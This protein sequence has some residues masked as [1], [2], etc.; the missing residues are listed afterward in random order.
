LL[1]PIRTAWD[2]VFEGIVLPEIDVF[3]AETMAQPAGGPETG[4]QARAREHAEN[5]ADAAG[6]IRAVDEERAT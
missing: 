4:R 1:R 5:G 3:D 2:V 6:L